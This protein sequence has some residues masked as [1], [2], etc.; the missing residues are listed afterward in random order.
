V[1]DAQR[2]DVFKEA[3]R[4]PNVDPAMLGAEVKIGDVSKGERACQAASRF[5][6]SRCKVNSSITRS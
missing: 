6:N 3:I 4:S 5:L 2:A 1:I